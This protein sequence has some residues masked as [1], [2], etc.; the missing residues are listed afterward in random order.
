MTTL[1]KAIYLSN[2]PAFVKGKGTLLRL[3]QSFEHERRS[4]FQL[5]FELIT[6]QILT[7]PVPHS[8]LST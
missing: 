1:L 3:K 2:V 5:S 7:L 4:M 8:A 6:M